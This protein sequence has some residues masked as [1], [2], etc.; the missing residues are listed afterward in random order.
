MLPTIPDTYASLRLGGTTRA[1]QVLTAWQAD[2]KLT[3]KT[4]VERAIALGQRPI[5]VERKLTG[6]KAVIEGAYADQA[7]AKAALDV[8]AKARAAKAIGEASKANDELVGQ[9][10][11]GSILANRVE[12]PIASFYEAPVVNPST[13]QWGPPTARPYTLLPPQKLQPTTTFTALAL[14][15]DLQI[16]EIDRDIAKIEN[17]VVPIEDATAKM[18]KE[19]DELAA[20]GALHVR[21]VGPFKGTIAWPETN[22]NAAPLTEGFRARA[23]DTSALFI[24][25]FRKQIE[26]EALAELESFYGDVVSMTPQERH[27]ELRKLRA[28]RRAVERVRIE[29]VWAALKAG[30]PG[31]VWHHAGADPYLLLGIERPI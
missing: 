30:E 28:A 5:D 19:F 16:E 24:R 6:N 21:R 31:D 17:S 7:A 29:A 10:A 4:P 3:D 18:R 22:I 1:E 26:A 12:P 15:K 2:K 25:H 27:D 14:S 13:R 20:K 11:D 8:G 9:L 23:V